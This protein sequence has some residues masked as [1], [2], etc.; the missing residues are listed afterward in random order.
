MKILKKHLIFTLRSGIILKLCGAR[1]KIVQ[2]QLNSEIEFGEL[3]E[4][5]EGARL[6]I[7]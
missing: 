6:E 2:H 4:L 3:S 5:A 1:Q 7:V